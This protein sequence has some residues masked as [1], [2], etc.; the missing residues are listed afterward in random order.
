MVAGGLVCVKSQNAGMVRKAP[1]DI[2]CTVLHYIRCESSNTRVGRG[3]AAPP[4]GSC[5]TDAFVGACLFF[6]L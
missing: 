2:C 4:P 5:G 1:E 3:S 6:P